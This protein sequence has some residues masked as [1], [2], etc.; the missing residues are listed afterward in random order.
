MA[1][2]KFEIDWCCEKCPKWPVTVFRI[3]N[4]LKNQYKWPK[5]D[6]NNTKLP[7]KHCFLDQCSQSFTSRDGSNFWLVF[8]TVYDLIMSSE[9]V[10][11]RSMTVMQ[12]VRNALARSSRKLFLKRLFYKKWNNFR[13]KN[14][15]KHRSLVSW[16]IK[17][18]Y[19]ILKTTSSV[20][21]ELWPSW[22]LRKKSYFMLKT[23]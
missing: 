20:R 3:V 4:S 13:T 14:H 2:I 22:I 17:L 5:L 1:W 23:L 9:T 7:L 15:A 19:L 11:K 21:A 16:S 18:F 10:M 12:T 6:L 8:T